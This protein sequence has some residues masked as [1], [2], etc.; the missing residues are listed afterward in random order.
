MEKLKIISLALLLVFGI[1][2]AVAQQ[3]YK[4]VNAMEV[5]IGRNIFGNQ[6]RHLS[7]SVSKYKS[8]T[9]YLKGGLNYLENSFTY[10][11]TLPESD[12]PPASIECHSTSKNY[13]ADAIYFKTL[14]TNRSFI[15]L[16]GGVGAFMGVESYKKKKRETQFLIGPEID[17]ETELFITSRIA[18]IGRVTQYWNPLSDIEK[19]N[20]IWDVGL[21]YLIY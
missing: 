16:N 14:F 20:T 15:Y 5:N 10:T 19:W 7:L 13:Y 18:F 8:R 12:L 17:L 9:T 21:K 6:D 2:N 4:G 1:K 3:H 11:K